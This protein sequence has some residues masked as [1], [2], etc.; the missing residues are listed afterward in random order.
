MLNFYEY[1]LPFHRPLITGSGT[2]HYR[3]GIILR[4]SNDRHDLLSETSPLPGFS[5][6]TLDEAKT[7]LFKNKETI[8]RFLGSDFSAGGV[9]TFLNQIPQAPS[10]QFS[11][12][13]L[14]VSLLAKR[15]KTSPGN[16]LGLQPAEEVLVN[17]MIGLRQSGDLIRKI[18]ES[19]AR[20]FTTIKIKVSESPYELAETLNLAA[21]RLEGLTF[22]LDANQSWPVDKLREF[23]SLFQDL[24]IQYIEEPVMMGGLNQ[25]NHVQKECALPVAL[26]ESISR[27]DA[28]ETILKKYPDLFVVIKPMLFGNIFKLTET[29]ST[30]RSRHKNV[31][32]TT[33]L[34]SKIGR[35]MTADLASYLG[36]KTLA[37]GLNTGRFLKRDLFPDLNINNGRIDTR[38]SQ[39]NQC[40][41]DNIDLSLLKTLDL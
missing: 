29:I 10:F 40:V 33:A 28:L 30:F 7:V 21:A 37:H 18:E 5:D 9:K 27:P 26:D 6:K 3:K 15:K 35:A 11:V 32:F 8:N 1:E 23:S 19:A 39:L 2:I 41:F 31:V 38:K 14:A 20:G 25:I 12:S 17:D 22:R 16:I 24:P 36:D 13:F 4:Y 34:E